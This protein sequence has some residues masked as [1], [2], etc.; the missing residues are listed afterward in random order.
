[1]PSFSLSQ[2][3]AFLIKVVMPF[4][5]GGSLRDRIATPSSG[6]RPPMSLVEKV[7]IIA[8][9]A[10]GM[11]AIHAH[12]IIH[13]DLKPENVLM[14]HLDEPL[15]TDFGLA[16]STNAASFSNSAG[17]RGTLHFKAPELCRSKKKGG[18]VI[19]PAADVYSFAV[20]AWHV[21]T[22]V[23]PWE[24][25]MDSEI[26]ASLVDGDRPELSEDGSVDWRTQTNPELA[27]LIEECWA[28]D[29]TQRPTFVDIAGRLDTI[30]S[31]LFG[32]GGWPH[33]RR[34]P[35]CNERWQPR[36]RLLKCEKKERK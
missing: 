24:G 23:Q 33:N 13:L 27:A 22:G 2:F 34:K 14:S 29:H 3:N 12:G 9:T 31:A 7:Q 36:P 16:A 15:I 11:A 1:M 28:Q 25:M 8:G 17:G 30:T 10:R 18:A 20:L 26:L 5:S 35:C 21:V 6:G 4:A 32:G 19:G